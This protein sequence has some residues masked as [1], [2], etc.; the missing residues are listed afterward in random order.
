MAIG[1]HRYYRLGDGTLIEVASNIHAADRF[2][3][4][5]KLNRR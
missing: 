2:N 5:V 3:Y 4:T 1:M